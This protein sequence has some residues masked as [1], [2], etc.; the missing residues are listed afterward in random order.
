M[1]AW[2][3][4]DKEM[5]EGSGLESEK[6]LGVPGHTEDT[7]KVRKPTRGCD[8]PCIPMPRRARAEP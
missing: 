8:N 2:A 6:V 1:G 7:D 3:A 4:Q 5:C